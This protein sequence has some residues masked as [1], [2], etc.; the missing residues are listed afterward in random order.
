MFTAI[1]DKLAELF[2]DID[3]MKNLPHLFVENQHANVGEEQEERYIDVSSIKLNKLFD[4][5]AHNMLS[6]IQYE[7][8]LEMFVNNIE[9]GRELLKATDLDELR[10]LS[11][12]KK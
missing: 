10:E 12:L 11:W 7:Q 4:S 5:I 8:A 1:C 2:P 3:E 6:T 9:L